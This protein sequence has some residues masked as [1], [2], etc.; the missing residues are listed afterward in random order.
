MDSKRGQLQ[1]FIPSIMPCVRTMVIHNILQIWS[2]AMVNAADPLPI[3]SDIKVLLGHCG[4]QGPLLITWINLN[5][6]P[7][8]INNYTHYKTYDE[9]TYPFPNFN[10]VAIDVWE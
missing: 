6:I 4:G 2:H 10:G 3:A 5:P 7:V 9:I 1:Q 8:W